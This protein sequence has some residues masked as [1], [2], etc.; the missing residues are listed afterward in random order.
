[1][2]KKKRSVNGMRTIEQEVR[3]DTQAK[4][5]LAVESTNSKNSKVTK[6]P[7]L[8]YLKQ[9]R[10]RVYTEK[11]LGIPTLN[12]SID[13]EGVKKPRGK[14][15]KVFADK[16]AM[17]RI[18]STVA[19]AQDSKNASRLEK[20]RQLE[21]I[22]EAKRLEMEKRE[23]DKEEKLNRKKSELKKRKRNNHKAAHD[24]FDQETASAKKKVS[25]A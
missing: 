15:G 25:F 5:L 8:P 12:K 1:M 3:T 16:D 10:Q 24:D 11:E 13:P 21:E 20:A 23:Q 7:V 17:L 14:K 18:L 4:N 6:P 19:E 2:S 9:K 22:R